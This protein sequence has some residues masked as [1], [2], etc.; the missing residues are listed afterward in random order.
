MISE[1]YSDD[2]YKD[3]EEEDFSKAE[4]RDYRIFNE[5]YLDTSDDED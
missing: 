1:S 5:D 3:F 2:I 4:L